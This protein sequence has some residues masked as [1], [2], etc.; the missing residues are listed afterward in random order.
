ML[1]ISLA[2]TTKE[3]IQLAQDWRLASVDEHACWALER[4]WKAASAS[5]AD[6]TDPEVSAR[7]GQ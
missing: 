1:V 4:G 5:Q 6:S 3:S 2:T 7:S